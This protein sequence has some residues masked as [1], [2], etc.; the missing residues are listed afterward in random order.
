MSISARSTRISALFLAVALAASQA[1]ARV[2]IEAGRDVNVAEI[3]VG[4]L[5]P[6]VAEAIVERFRAGA[7]LE[8]AL[9]AAEGE[10]ADLRGR[11]EQW[12]VTRQALDNFFR[13]AGEKEVPR[14]RIV[15]ALAEIA[16]RHVD[17]LSRLEALTSDDPTVG[18]LTTEAA[19]ALESGDYDQAD[20]LL[21]RAE[22]ADLAAAAQALKIAEHAASA[23]AERFRRAAEARAERAG[24]ARTR[25]DYRAAASHFAEAA[26][27]VE[28]ADDAPLQWQYQLQRATAL[29]ELGRDFGDHSALLEAISLYRNTVLPLAPRGV[30]P[31][32]WGMTQNN[33]GNAL[34][35]LGSRERGTEWLEQAVAAFRASLEEQTRE[36]SPIGWA[37]AQNNLGNAFMRLAE[38]EPG[39]ERFE[40]AILAYR[41]SLEEQTRQIEPIGWAQ[42]QGNLGAALMG[43]GE[44]DGDLRW[45]R[46][47][48]AAF[49][50]AL[51]EQTRERN[52]VGWAMTQNNLGNA[53]LRLG[54][55]E[56][57]AEQLE[58]SVVAFRAAL[59]EQTRERLPLGWAEVQN[60]LGN[61]LV[62]LAMNDG[63][64][65]WLEQGETAYRAAFEE[66]NA[67]N[68]LFNAAQV[69]HNLAILQVAF[70]MDTGD[71]AKLD[72]AHAAARKADSLNREI[73]A[74]HQ[75]RLTQDLLK[76]IGDLR[77]Q[78]GD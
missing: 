10:L 4:S 35:T 33:L 57:D 68:A 70:F 65:E 76:M 38:R 43:L 27:I 31:L 77:D 42:V 24:I 74:N 2:E 9:A 64:T 51:E 5:P 45:Y 32:D 25:L 39:T 23:A 18:S 49:R 46:E 53:L 20:A 66:F 19:K 78:T 40:Q 36:A 8:K 71:A 58:A 50:A 22:D 14:E 41:A 11:L 48:V 55:L 67:K 15:V 56:E 3:I 28:R 62:T 69:Q 44:R 60:N 17:A 26:R 29:Q 21:A 16:E 37:Q 1:V 34:E 13:I 6:E 63:G 75:I 7:E 30:R 12:G 61:A 52:R 59:E 72:E 54:Q 47:A 73:G